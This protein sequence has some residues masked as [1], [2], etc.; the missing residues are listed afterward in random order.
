[1]TCAVRVFVF[2]R[3]GYEHAAYLKAWLAWVLRYFGTW[4][5]VHATRFSYGSTYLLRTVLSVVALY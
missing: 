2:F 3:G 1:M 5:L 4:V